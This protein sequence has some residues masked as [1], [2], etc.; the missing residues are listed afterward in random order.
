MR[1]FE[2]IRERRGK[3]IRVLILKRAEDDPGLW[4]RVNEFP[5]T[6]KGLRD[7]YAERFRL[8]QL[9]ETMRREA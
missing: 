5:G 6:T 9:D 2:V 7:A 1:D 3:R 4:D 8:L